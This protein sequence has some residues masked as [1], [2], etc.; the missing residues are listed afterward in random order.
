[1]GDQVK[2]AIV[3]V[4]YNSSPDLDR[5]LESLVACAPRAE[6]QVVIVDNA[7]RDEGL[8]EVHQRYPDFTWIFSNENAGYSRGCNLGM[9]QVEADYYLVLNP[10]IVVQPGALDSLLAFA[11]AHPRAGMVGPQLLNEDGSIQESCRRF[12][13]FTT[14]LLRRTILGK[15][16][17]NSETV[18][19]HLMQDFDHRSSRPVDWV[20]GGC[21]L[22]R[23]SAMDRTGP[24]D[25]RFFL[26]FEDV[27][28]CYR[29]WQAGFEVLYCPDAR[30][31]HRHR[32]DS[33]KGAL[34]R[35]FW[36]HLASL[37]SFFEKWGIVVWL[38]KKWRDP[39]LVFLLWL[40]DMA[41]LTVAFLAAYA[42]RGLLGGIFPGLFAE[43][44]FPLGEY[45]PLL[46]F[47][48]LLSSLTFLMTGRYQAGRLRQSRPAG[49]HLKQI[50]AVAVLLMASS[51]LGHMDVISRAVLLLFIPL[52]T[53]TTLLGEV[54]FRALFA[55]LER[56]RLSLERTLLVGSPSGI[57]A[58]LA[59]SRGLAEHLVGH[60]VDIAGYIANPES[61]GS[62]LPPLG[63]GAIPW[64]GPN[65]RILE[66]VQRYRIS[67]VVFWE[68]PAADAT[69]WR[70]LAGLRRLRVRLRWQ[71]PD[72]WLLAA[73]T[74][75]E[76]FGGQLSA[77][78]GS[79]ST[80]VLKVLA[81]RA[82]SLVAGLF[83]G[84]LGWLPW[85]LIK[86]V[87]APRGRSR[88]ERVQVTDLWGH[89]PELLLALD[90]AG[91]PRALPWQW[92]LSGALMRGR[93]SVFGP[94]SYLGGQVDFP[95]GPD[96]VLEFWQTDP[97]A[98]GLTGKWASGGA[99]G[100]SAGLNILKQ[101]WSDP[102]GFGTVVS[103]DA[104]A[105]EPDSF[106]RP[107]GEVV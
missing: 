5:C 36:M 61:S 97:A 28:W 73:R 12:Y 87:L 31:M 58:W 13:T 10:D 85:L 67:Q 65:D 35:S 60:G 14:L 9:S 6:H 59:G 80:T 82:V 95:E 70:D 34:N 47:S 18:R 51:Y 24:M 43:P 92:R 40:A 41:G 32:R 107:G 26:Y 62:G 91:L 83:L 63:G 100:L 99:T 76:L 78:Q 29:M 4:H 30:F 27:D 54:G 105:P 42:L 104:A 25:E 11:D 64:L 49:E 50:G 57:A 98:P 68:R 81:S 52:L 102:G 103:P 37:I 48:A 90:S 21:L 72:V 1:M 16:F 20:L 88:V 55:R 89:D 94:R 8:T 79:Q 93:L 56:G 71:V 15:I 96:G 84:L 46:L 17:P 77:V 101:L 3:I 45:Q 39:L 66:V 2:L 44:L 33:A 38:V 75:A 23:R 86:L 22:V 7:S 106:S 69:A 19:L 74:R 53:L